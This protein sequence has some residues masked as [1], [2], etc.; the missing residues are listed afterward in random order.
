MK[1]EMKENLRSHYNIPEVNRLLQVV[2]FLDPQF[3]RLPF[4]SSLEQTETHSAI[5]E[6]IYLRR[7]SNPPQE[8]LKREILQQ[9]NTRVMVVNLFVPFLLGC[10][11]PHHWMKLY[12]VTEPSKNYSDILERI[13]FPSRIAIAIMRIITP[14]CGGRRTAVGSKLLPSWLANI[15]AYLPLVSHQKDYSAQRAALLL[16]LPDMLALILTMLICCVL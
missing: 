8:T 3:K 13:P 1:T 2:C 11:N 6:E 4:L 14:L 9:R 16:Q 10:F 5:R 15:C 7:V 12:H